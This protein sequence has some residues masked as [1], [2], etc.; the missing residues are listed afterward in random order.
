[1]SGRKPI[2]A[3]CTSA[4]R[5]CAWPPTAPID[6]TRKPT[7]EEVGTFYWPKDPEKPIAFRRPTEESARKVDEI[8]LPEL[9]ALAREILVTGKTGEA[10]IVAMARELGLHSL[11]AVTRGRIEQAVREAGEA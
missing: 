2:S 3:A 7:S 4:C 8:C 6:S 11:R 5:T 10:A 1:M 9:A